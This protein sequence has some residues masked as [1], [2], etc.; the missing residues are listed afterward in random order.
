MPYDPTFLLRGF[1]IGLSIAAPVGPI[2]V[3]CI[4]RTL[5]EGR[6]VGFV[7]GL[8]AATADATYGAIAGF[9]LTFVSA[10]LVQQQR[11]IHLVGGVF[12]LYLGFTTFRSVPSERAAVVKSVED[13]REPMPRRFSSLLRTRSR[14]CHSSRSS[15]AS[16]TATNA[17]SYQWGGGSCGWSVPRI[18]NLV[19]HPVGGVG[20]FSI[21]VHSAWAGVG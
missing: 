3:L 20:T 16:G 15:P 17:R 7:S 9:G 4:R 5:A 12:L 1:L 11:W 14:Y 19:A 21:R 2:G 8:G 13:W 10:L 18:G 6:V